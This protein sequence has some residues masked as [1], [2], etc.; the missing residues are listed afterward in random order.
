MLRRLE[1]GKTLPP[2]HDYREVDPTGY[3]HCCHA[4]APRCLYEV[5]NYVT[6]VELSH[7]S[8]YHYLCFPL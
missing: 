3:A 6:D 7:L 5:L 2:Q 4:V 1:N 8:L